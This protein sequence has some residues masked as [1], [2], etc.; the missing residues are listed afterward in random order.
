MHTLLMTGAGLGL[1]AILFA[2]L[3]TLGL[4]RSSRAAARGAGLFA[5]LWLAV[6]AASFAYGVLVAGQPVATEV[7]VHAIVLG[8][9]LV[10]AILYAK[11]AARHDPDR[12][13]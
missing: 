1:L 13:H 5:L 6:S 7:A 9:P 10:A 11:W 3:R 12:P 8:I 2:T 4:A